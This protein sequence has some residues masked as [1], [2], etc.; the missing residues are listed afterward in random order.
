MHLKTIITTVA[1]VLQMLI[2]TVPAEGSDVRSRATGDTG[3]PFSKGVPLNQQQYQTI[4]RVQAP[5]PTGQKNRNGGLARL[6]GK[7]ANTG[8]ARVSASGAMLQGM[9]IDILSGEK[10]W[11]ELTTDG[12]IKP[13]WN[14]PSTF[15]NTGFIR[16]G[17]IYGF[18]SQAFMGY[19]FLGHGVFGMDG[20]LIDW[21]DDDDYF[22]NFSRY[23]IQC[24]Y[25][26]DTDVAYAYTLNSDASAYMFQK[27]DPETS[28]FTVINDNV[29]LEE[30]CN[31]M[32]WNASDG[33]LYGFTS[34]CRVCRI[35][36]NT[37]S[38]T[39]L[40]KVLGYGIS[41][42]CH[43]MVYSPLDKAYF[44]VICNSDLN[45]TPM[46]KVDPSDWTYRE[47]AKLPFSQFPILEC[48]D[49]PMSDEAPLAP[50]ISSIDFNGPA[51]SGI[52]VITAPERTFGGD[53]LTGDLTLSISVDDE[54]MPDAVMTPGE[55]K[56]I[57]LD[58]TEG[59]HTLRFK[60]NAASG[61]ESPIAERTVYTG[62]DV[63][64]APEKV[65]FGEGIVTWTPVTEGLN[66]A[67]I[68]PEG[69]VYD[70][71]LDGTAVVTSVK[72]T[73]YSFDMPDWDYGVHTAGVVAVNHTQRSAITY[74]NSLT[75]GRS[76]ELPLVIKPEE[77]QMALL[78]T[79]DVNGD[80]YGWEKYVSYDGSI[81]CSTYTAG[82]SDDW[83]L[84]P[85]VAM[86]ASDKLYKVSFE[87]RS[88]DPSAPDALELA[89]SDSGNIADMKTVSCHN[90][91]SE[92]YTTEEAFIYAPSDCNAR[93]GFHAMSPGSGGGL[94]IRNIKVELSESSSERPSAPTILSA[95]PAPEGALNAEV[96]V[97]M[98]VKDAAGR[99][100][101]ADNKIQCVAIC[102]EEKV[103]TP[104]APGE[105]VTVT[106]PTSQGFNNIKV[107]AT[108][109]DEEGFPA[110]VSI[111]TGN[112][113]PAAISSL[114]ATPTDDYMGV[115]LSWSE[116][117]SGMNGGYIRPGSTQY[118]L[119]RQD[120]NN[121]WQI[122]RE[123]GNTTSCRYD[124]PAGS[125]LAIEYFAI[126]CGNELGINPMIRLTK[127][128]L[129]T[130]YNL[131]LEES[132]DGYEVHCTPVLDMADN[133][134]YSA[135]WASG[136]NSWLEA[137]AEGENFT[138][139]ANSDNIQSKGL[140]MLPR[141][142]TEGCKDPA[143]DFT[144]L[145][146]SNMGKLNV[147]AMLHGGERKL[148]GTVDASGY[149]S[150]EWVKHRM[151]LGSMFADKKAVTLLLESEFTDP[152]QNNVID[153]YKIRNV[154]ENEFDSIV[155]TATPFVK[156]GGKLGL[157]FSMENAGMYTVAMPTVTVDLVRDGN[158]LMQME[159]VSD[160][161]GELPVFGKAVY[162]GEFVTNA[163]V[164]GKLECRFEISGME[165]AV[166]IADVYTD[167]DPVVDDLKAEYDG[168]S[169]IRLSWTEPDIPAGLENFE[170]LAAWCYPDSIGEFKNVDRDSLPG[171][172]FTYYSFPYDRAAK[173]FQIFSE[174]E[175]ADIL[176][177]AFP[178]D[179]NFMTA[180]SGDK[181][182]V[183]I[184]PFGAEADDWF[185]S[186]EIAGGSEVSFMATI[187]AGYMEEM[188]V[189]YSTGNAD[190]ESFVMLER[191][192]IMTEGWK[193]FEYKLPDD[194]RYFAIRHIGNNFAL[195][196]DDIKYAPV[197]APAAVDHYELMRDDV[198]VNSNIPT[199]GS[200]TDIY[201]PSDKVSYCIIPLT[202]GIRGMMS[203]TA[204]IEVSS[205][206]DID[207]THTLF[208]DG[209]AI[210]AEGCEGFV[211]RIWNA[212]GILVEETVCSDRSSV[213]L[214]S[215]VY[216]AT[217]SSLNL[218]CVIK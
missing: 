184:A 159:L 107:Y 94:Y 93:I 82:A 109:G 5:M 47:V 206:S 143:I 202:N 40:V 169:S 144:V 20:T 14:T 165:Y 52:A 77:E 178:D 96:K 138:C 4:R 2:C 101:Q 8:Q 26:A 42:A 1:L 97:K 13:L 174:R 195:C 67:Y 25:D 153:G 19:A 76:L 172:Y 50:V 151:V 158:K 62:Y 105:E 160:S 136:G 175:F 215:G 131:P 201:T 171:N 70:V 122:V 11:C 113:I 30:I 125:P 190:P 196:I 149:T 128:M 73:E 130:P 102:G 12:S 16:Q 187:V 150:P 162:S 147:Y 154:N 9:K 198:C 142:S 21:T 129:G 51:L 61:I 203:N 98:P 155:A 126:A 49:K 53:T 58:L 86:P 132:F 69:P 22:D 167:M 207:N 216:V 183:S 119:C 112:D 163:E 145:H 199:G 217:V 194:A 191:E 218:K 80:F 74:S 46:V 100:L 37:G 91:F 90:G 95:I 135:T 48:D 211:L 134:E 179:A 188:E 152:E 85:P 127:E 157:S 72:G 55:T 79:V 18:S 78:E 17:K 33:M 210:V 204:T 186:P 66:G 6:A 164:M 200:A 205:V 161:K 118:Y 166:A 104:A 27:I 38:L 110:T 189:L 103:M 208:V 89:W 34:D 81:Q 28:T 24:A 68:D 121:E 41:T 123:L 148:I 60:I 115:V 111:F 32:T 56:R 7:N 114:I 193:N 45:D 106:L 140:L 124:M 173:A 197:N 168:E 182:A 209:D 39:Q 192:A 185:I 92:D 176:H 116:P 23:V 44:I 117:E 64:V 10:Q 63:P 75:T 87:T 181:F 71:Y 212:D 3:Q 35:D 57:S 59:K 214:P 43:G 99:D 139:W 83:L 133:S 31:G 88:G 177:S 180:Y 137:P 120:E 141:F 54:S 213:T 108:R 156:V 146:H 15:I 84:L 36:T 29:P 170:R 65:T